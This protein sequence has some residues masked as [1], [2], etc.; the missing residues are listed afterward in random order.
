MGIDALKPAYKQIFDIRINALQN[1]DSVITPIP[2]SPN[3]KNE[4][5]F[6]SNLTRYENN[7]VSHSIEAL[8]SILEKELD[9]EILQLN[10]YLS[11]NETLNVIQSTTAFW[12]KFQKEMPK[13]FQLFIVLFNICPS[14]AFIERFFS[15]CG[16]IN[17]Q[18][19]YNMKKDLFIIKSLLKAN[20]EL[21]G[22]LQLVF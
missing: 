4:L 10:S 8:E 15:I 6:F 13:I 2:P 11:N 20:S 7:P 5:S 1:N 9:K 21:L 3:S 22:E 12:I 18:R 14:S 17:N 16:I 19:S